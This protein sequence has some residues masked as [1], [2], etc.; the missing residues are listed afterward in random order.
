MSELN[1]VPKETPVHSPGIQGNTVAIAIIAA[2]TI[3]TLTCI[4][5]ATA[6]MIAFF[7]NAPW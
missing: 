4:I 6:V 2:V 7:V 1:S 5:S 3:I